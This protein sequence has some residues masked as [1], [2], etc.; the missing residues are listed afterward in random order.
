MK[1][2]DGGQGR[3]W[4]VLKTVQLHFSLYMFLCCEQSCQNQISK[5]VLGFEVFASEFAIIL[6]I[7]TD[8]LWPYLCLGGRWSQLPLKKV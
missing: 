4:V 2:L 1:S 5:L 7:C 6:Q 8:A 3:R